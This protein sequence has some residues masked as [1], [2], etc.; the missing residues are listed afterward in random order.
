MVARRSWLPRHL[1]LVTASL[2]LR[3]YWHARSLS[4]PHG[5]HNG[6]KALTSPAGMRGSDWSDP[7]EMERAWQ[8]ALVRVPDPDGGFLSTT[9]AI[10]RSGGSAPPGVWPTVIYMHGRACIWPGTLAWINF[11]A[12]SGYAAL[13]TESFARLKYPR[14]CRPETH[15]GGPYRPVLRMRQNDAGHAIASVKALPWVASENVILMRPS[16]GGITTATYA[17]SGPRHLVRARIVEG[18]TIQSGW[19]ERAGINASLTAPVST[20]MGAKDP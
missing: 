7:A 1:V 3:G 2:A 5:L 6:T 13:A 11:L 15:E 8:A 14:S 20:L 18:W 4:I 19:P 9:I 12:R 10:L 17:G 16:E